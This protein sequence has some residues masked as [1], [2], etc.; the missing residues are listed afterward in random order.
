MRGNKSERPYMNLD[1]LK[2]L[3]MLDVRNWTALKNKSERFQGLKNRELL[4][5]KLRL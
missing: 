3:K 5:S 2:W 1:G 4:A